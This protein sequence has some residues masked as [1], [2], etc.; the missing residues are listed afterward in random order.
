MHHAHMMFRFQDFKTVI[1]SSKDT[2]KNELVKK[3]VSWQKSS[4]LIKKFQKCNLFNILGRWR[5][6]ID[7]SWLEKLGLRAFEIRWTRNFYNSAL[8]ILFS[9]TSE[10]SQC[11]W[12]FGP[13]H[14]TLMQVDCPVFE[15]KVSGIS[16]V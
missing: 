2:Q 3:T 11:G 15:G 4:D 10:F 7:L 8:T 16:F 1:T 6:Q 9:V 5:K 12:S 14:R 13:D